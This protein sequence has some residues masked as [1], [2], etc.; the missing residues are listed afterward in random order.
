MDVNVF[1]LKIIVMER[2]DINMKEDALKG[3][4]NTTERERNSK[5]FNNTIVRLTIVYDKAV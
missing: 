4:T 5:L 2:F 3:T 1:K